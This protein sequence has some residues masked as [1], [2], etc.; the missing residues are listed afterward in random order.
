MK[1]SPT[2]PVA[3][4]PR[5]SNDGSS[6][7]DR[8]SASS[9]PSAST[10]GARPNAEQK[11]YRAH[12]HQPALSADAVIASQ[13]EQTERLERLVEKL[14]RVVTAPNGATAAIGSPNTPAA[15][16]QADLDKAVQREIELGKLERTVLA[17]GHV[18]YR[19]PIDSVRNLGYELVGKRDAFVDRGE[20]LEL[21]GSGSNHLRAATL[22]AA[23]KWGSAPVVIY[24]EGKHLDAVIE[25]AVR[26]GLNIANEHPTIV[27]KVAAERERQANP[28]GRE[29]AAT[30]A[31]AI[32]ERDVAPIIA[33]VRSV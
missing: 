23:R 25:H 9:R 24:A 8:G 2:P 33:R 30:S 13:R 16:R 22:H 14:S 20:H 4:T 31:R 21:A 28:L 15:D 12:D 5:P 19:L 11:P 27:A 7:P 10:S 29:R 17:N 26:A 6:A 3:P 1:V 32:R 18:S